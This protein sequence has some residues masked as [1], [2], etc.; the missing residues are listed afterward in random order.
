MLDH[1]SGRRPSR[2]PPSSR[3]SGGGGG[4]V[5]RRTPREWSRHHNSRH[6]KT[7]EGGFVPR[8]G[9]RRPNLAG[10]TGGTNRGTPAADVFR[11]AS[12]K[13]PSGRGRPLSRS[14]PAPTHAQKTPLRRSARRPSGNGPPLEGQTQAFRRVYCRP[15]LP[16]SPRAARE[17]GVVHLA[18]RR[19]PSQPGPLQ[20]RAGF[21]KP[22]ESEVRVPLRY[23]TVAELCFH[24]V[25]SV[26]THIPS[27]LRSGG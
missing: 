21:R 24:L 22:Q 20:G 7:A 23:M 9:R 16:P 4:C 14:H 27:R 19:G 12:P 6:P 5:F 17:G 10:R 2:P 26:Q 25:A 13:K 15:L 3:G 11:S 18:D 8:Q 1:G